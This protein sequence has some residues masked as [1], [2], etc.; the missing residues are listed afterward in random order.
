MKHHAFFV[1]A[2]LTAGAIAV[3]A[4]GPA[5][6]RTSQTTVGVGGI[7]V[8]IGTGPVVTIGSGSTP[9]TTPVSVP[10]TTPVPASSVPAPG[11][12]ATVPAPRRRA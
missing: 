11:V 6:A 3:L 1:R 5:A 8:Q 10:V 12:D 7:G 4:I 9:V 2:A